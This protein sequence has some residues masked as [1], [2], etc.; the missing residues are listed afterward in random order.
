M[1][2]FFVQKAH[3]FLGNDGTKESYPLCCIECK[4]RRYKIHVVI[5]P[6]FNLQKDITNI[7]YI[8]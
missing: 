4:Q 8:K 6:S 3:I 5:Y 2:F 1:G 7:N